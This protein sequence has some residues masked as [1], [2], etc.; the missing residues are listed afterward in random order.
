MT[1]L[2]QWPEEIPGVGKRSVGPLSRCSRCPPDASVNV[3]ATFARYGETT[4]C[5]ACARE[6]LG[7][8]S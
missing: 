3:A 4:L 7:A 2:F 6:S 8:D 1:G 5:L